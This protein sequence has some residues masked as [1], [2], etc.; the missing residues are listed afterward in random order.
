MPLSS[1]IRKGFD[2]SEGRIFTIPPGVPF[3]KVL[4]RSLTDGRLVPSFRL[5]PDNPMRLAQATIY[6][7]TRRAARALRS[8]FVDLMEGQSTI[9]PVIRPLGEIDDDAGFFDEVPDANLDLLP[10]V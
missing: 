8:E 2:M 1:A 6:V 7:P 10:P 4:T 5:T 3:L 9:L